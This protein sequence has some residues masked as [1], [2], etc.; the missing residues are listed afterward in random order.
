[1]SS[2]GLLQLISR[3]V[4]AAT[5]ALGLSIGAGLLPATPVAAEAAASV[6]P[7]TP[8]PSGMADNPFIP[9]NANLG[10]CVSSLPRPD[11]GTDQRSGYHQYL[12]LIVLFLGTVFIG[13]RIA[14]GVRSRD[15]INNRV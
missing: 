1:V 7:V 6:P 9:E 11:C 15:R 12:T 13:W 8:D 5:L 4:A 10:D 3:P 14:R 2:R